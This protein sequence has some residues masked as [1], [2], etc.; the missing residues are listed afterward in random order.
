MHVACRAAPLPG[1]KPVA[2][3]PGQLLTVD[4]GAYCPPGTFRDPQASGAGTWPCFSVSGLDCRQ[5]CYYYSNHN[6]SVRCTFSFQM[7]FLVLSVDFLGVSGRCS[8]WPRL[9]VSKQ[10][11]WGL[12]GWF[13][14]KPLSRGKVVQGWMLAFRA[15]LCRGLGP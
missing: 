11:R 5:K 6:W 14:S 9:I 13:G 2:P 15:G 4:G 3:G 7:C 10:Q 8:A 12:T 1:P